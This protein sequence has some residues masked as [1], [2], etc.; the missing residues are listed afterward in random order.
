MKRILFSIVFISLISVVFANPG[1][2]TD[3]QKVKKK[4]TVLVVPICSKEAGDIRNRLSISE[5]AI[6]SQIL[7]QTKILDVIPE[8]A[9]AESFKRAK[10]DYLNTSPKDIVNSAKL[11]P[12]SDIVIFVGPLQND[13]W[14]NWMFANS[15]NWMG[16]TCSILLTDTR[17]LKEKGV[18]E[19]LYERLPQSDTWVSSGGYQFNTLNAIIKDDFKDYLPIP[20]PNKSQEIQ[21]ILPKDTMVPALKGI[22][23]VLIALAKNGSKEDYVEASVYLEKAEKLAPIPYLRYWHAV[24]LSR[25]GKKDEAE[26]IVRDLLSSPVEDELRELI[27]Q[28][29]K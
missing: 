7:R 21:T 22:S 8:I 18:G 19:Y 4:L 6:T 15:T 11:L 16:R 3:G 24:A 28:I 13:G 29:N 27:L 14:F 9:V 12:Y 26:N 5:A 20:E 25:Q 2:K 17:E 23:S 10:L 1:N